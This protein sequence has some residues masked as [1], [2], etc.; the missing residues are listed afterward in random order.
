[1]K[2]YRPARTFRLRVSDL[3]AHAGSG[4]AHKVSTDRRS[5]LVQIKG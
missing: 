1:M 2:W 3:V 5:H 4:N